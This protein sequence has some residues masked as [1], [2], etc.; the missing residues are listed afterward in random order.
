MK[1]T[2]TMAVLLLAA[3][4]FSFG[5][6]KEQVIALLYDI[7]ENRTKYGYELIAI[8]EFNFGIPGG[9]AN[10][11]VEWKKDSI[12]APFM[13][14]VDI[15]TWEIKFRAQIG[16]RSVDDRLD[17]SC[18]E[19]FP[20]VTRGDGTY[21]IG[22]FNGDGLDEVAAFVA[23][24]ISP[25]FSIEGYDPQENKVKNYCYIPC[26]YGWGLP[27]EFIM[28]KGMQGFMVYYMANSVWPDPP[29]P[30]NGRWYFY[31]WN[32]WRREYVEMGVVD[33]KYIGVEPEPVQTQ[34]IPIAPPVANPAPAEIYAPGAA[35]E[36]P[37]EG[38]AHSDSPAMLII[39]LIGG[40][41]VVGVAVIL[42]AKRKKKNCRL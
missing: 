16:L 22:D 28:Y 6:E 15:D 35:A 37:P 42:L 17:P 21:Q 12:I 39:A 7:D 18:Y 32:G 38:T 27:V 33:P 2:V 5:Q 3:S 36:E 20:G 11:L 13:Y 41:V 10:W 8:E 29:D 26:A 9:G 24:A 1:K 34:E 31:A 23:L 30:N 25:V 4:V 19:N 14:V 40:A